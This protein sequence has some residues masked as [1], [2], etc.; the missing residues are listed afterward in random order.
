MAEV[1]AYL[2]DHV[3]PHLPLRQWVL[4]LPK[5]LRPYLHHDPEVGGAPDLPPSPRD[6]AAEGES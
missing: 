6:H 3:L 2:T 5:R 4:S 1:G